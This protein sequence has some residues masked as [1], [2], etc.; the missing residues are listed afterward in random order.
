MRLI[1]K[2]DFPSPDGLYFTLYDN[3]NVGIA[4]FVEKKWYSYPNKI[5][6]NNAD[7][8]WVYLPEFD[9]ISNKK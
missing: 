4:L 1:H 7:F 5:E 6:L 9:F 2:N 8:F 3:G